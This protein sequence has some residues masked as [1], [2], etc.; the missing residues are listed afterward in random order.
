MAGTTAPPLLR[1]EEVLKIYGRGTAFAGLFGRAADRVRAVDGVSLQVDRGEV[2]GLVGESG[3]GKSTL[4][5]LVLGL[6]TPTAGRVLFEG[7]PTAGLGRGEW[8]AFRRRV[9][10]VFQDPHGSLNP[11]F[12]IGETVEEPLI[13]H[14]LGAAPERARRV[15]AALEEAELRPGRAYRDRYPHELSGGQRQRVAIARA[16]V[17]EPALLIADEPVSMLDVSVRAGILRL[18][19]RL[20]RDHRMAMVFITHDLSLIGQMCD[21]VAILYRG[22]LVELGAAAAVMA[23]PR[24]PYTRQLIAAVPIPDPDYVPPPAAPAAAVDAT[25]SAGCRF[26]PRCPEAIAICRQADPPLVAVGPDRQGACHRLQ[27]E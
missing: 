11:R 5:D 16:I 9:Q 19:R 3:S 23:R 15:L 26:A 8:R 20:V 2:L 13:I 4:A 25:P 14:G 1:L 17:L 12:T 27:P 21:T 18:L 24:H 7:R 6:E 22:K 10:M